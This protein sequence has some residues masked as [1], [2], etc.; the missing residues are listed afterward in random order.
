M[1]KLSEHNNEEIQSSELGAGLL[2][3]LDVA[4]V[5]K[6]QQD[7]EDGLVDEAISK[8]RHLPPPATQEQSSAYARMRAIIAE[9]LT[10]Q[11]RAA[12]VFDVL[13]PYDTAVSR[14]RLPLHERALVSLRLGE[15]YCATLNYPSSVALLDEAIRYAGLAEDRNLEASARCSLGLVYCY[16]GE[17]VIAQEHLKTALNLF[18]KAADKRG[19]AQVYLYSGLVLSGL[20]E[21]GKSIEFYNRSIALAEE[22]KDE[23]IISEGKVNL[24]TAFLLQGKA[25]KAIKLYEVTV[26][27]FEQKARIRLAAQTYNNLAHSLILTGDWS[28]AEHILEKSL[29]LSRQNQDDY[30]EAMALGMFG[31]LYVL[32]GR[33]P[34][35]KQTLNFSIELAR[36]INSKD[37]E[38]FSEINLGRVYLSLGEPAHAIAFLLAGLEI[39][40]TI[41]RI[42]YA[43]EAHLLLAEAYL[44]QQEK[45]Q[46]EE[47]VQSAKKLIARQPNYLLEGKLLHC[48]GR[49]ALADG[50]QDALSLLSRAIEIFEVFSYPFEKGLCFLDRATV[51]GE[52]RETLVKAIADVERA[53]Q[54]FERLNS[55]QLLAAAREHLKALVSRL[56]KSKGEGALMHDKILEERRQIYRLIKACRSREMVIKEM[57]ENLR[58]QS[59]ADLVAIYEVDREGETKLLTSTSDLVLLKGLLDRRLRESIGTNKRAWIG[60]RG[61]DEPF[62]L[63]LLPLSPEKQLAIVIWLVPRKLIDPEA[64]HAL[65]EI[66]G[67]L[68]TIAARQEERRVEVNEVES[69]RIRSFKGLPDLV[70]AGK[71][72]IELTEQL[73]RI[74][75][76]DLT[77]LIT[78]ESGTGKELIARAIHSVSERRASPFLPFNC[79][80]TPSEI[81]EAQLFGYRKGAFTGANI[82]YEGVIRAASGGTLLLDEIGDLHLSIQPKLLRFLQEGEIQPIGYSRPIQVDVRVIASTN[83]ELEVMVERGEFRE[84]LYHRLNIIRLSVPPLRQRRD[85][86]ALL[87]DLFLKQSCHRTGKQLSFS[88]EAMFVIESFDWPG[89]VRQL[90]NE[91]ERIVAFA[92]EGDVIE[93]YQLSSEIVQAAANLKLNE[94]A[95]K[96]ATDFV[97]KSGH[98]LEEIL[99]ATEREVIVRAIKQCR[100]NIRRTAI[101]LGVSRKGLYDKIKRLKIKYAN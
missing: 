66:V 4:A 95:L 39:A 65:L 64:T 97:S 23:Q 41:N 25:R 16:L 80:A 18:T 70:Y 40:L 15:A 29:V 7:L 68:L 92:G 26:S 84:D 49:L 93:K 83:R 9:R 1:T 21:I 53:A 44:L 88:P 50:K 85:E 24:A 73:L 6:I 101:L 89:N 59:H 67:E 30:G 98:T 20:G 36:Q 14:V 11:G 27:E 62:Y 19:E 76:S 2:G 100:G 61:F 71:K 78:G 57:A 32:T 55:T 48:E 52:H 54:M 28:R 3:S 13:Q 56:P 74:Q 86:V 12:G 35:A 34:T 77:V 58:R 10:T 75:S 8:Q 60:G 46:A 17:Y 45:E 43:V 37:C 81:V 79:T 38:S 42:G 91:I 33:I 31:L 87:A 82:D 94:K 51:M 96:V 72:M 90:K 22:I 69:R 47:V 63:D 99:A 5:E